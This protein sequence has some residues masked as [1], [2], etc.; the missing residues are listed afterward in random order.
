MKNIKRLTFIELIIVIGIISILLGLLLPCPCSNKKQSLKVKVM[1][2]I[3]AIK[4]ALDSFYIEYY[5]Y[6]TLGKTKADLTGLG[7]ID[8]NIRKLNFFSGNF[9]DEWGNKDELS[10][11]VVHKGD[12]FYSRILG[13]AKEFPEF[14]AKLYNPVI[15]KTGR[16]GD[17][18]EILRYPDK[19][20]KL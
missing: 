12:T 17:S 3:S 11:F 14:D 2:K 19:E 8:K 1:G 13:D 4:T 15:V 20:N 16:G 9:K 5:Q 6:P 10:I 7:Q 18:N